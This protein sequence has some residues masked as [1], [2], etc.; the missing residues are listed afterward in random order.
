[1]LIDVCLQGKMNEYHII[2]DLSFP[3][4]SNLMEVTRQT[5][6]LLRP[7]SA[8]WSSSSSSLRKRSLVTILKKG[9]GS[10][11][12]NPQKPPQDKL[13]PRQFPTLSSLPCDPKESLNP[14]RQM[15]QIS[16]CHLVRDTS[17]SL[18]RG[19]RRPMYYLDHQNRG[20]TLEQCTP[21]RKIFDER[22]STGEVCFRENRQSGP[23]QSANFF[24]R[25][26]PSRKLFL[27]ILS[28]PRLCP[29]ISLSS[30]EIYN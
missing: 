27:V 16:D 26:V 8:S 6:E 7:S 12:S 11:S 22:Y 15:G 29:F 5:N 13:G 19:L 3:S 30:H 25:S 10:R 24:Y 18:S 1:M 9:V 20:H 4:F 2:L 14:P 21:F 23:S 28:T 17:S